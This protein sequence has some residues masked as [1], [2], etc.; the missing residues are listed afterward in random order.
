MAMARERAFD[1]EAF[2]AE[3]LARPKYADVHPDTVRGVARLEAD[4]HRARKAF[5]KSTRARLH[6]LWAA[7]LGELDYDKDMAILEKAFAS[8]DPD[9][10]EATCR[11]LMATHRSTRERLEILSEF[12]AA[13]F[14]IAGFPGVV[15]DLACALHPLGLRAMGLREPFVYHAY[16]I[17]RRVVDFMGRYFA[18]EG[19]AGTAHWRDVLCAPPEETGDVAFLLK[20]YHCLEL[21]ERGAGMRVV[22]ATPARWLAVSF[23]TRTLASKAVDIASNYEGRIVET[24]GERGWRVERLDFATERVFLIDKEAP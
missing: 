2:V 19:I 11:R 16:D 20:M 12:Y 18:L 23:P 24:A 6:R 8:D 21:R 14:S 13:V 17:N 9:D 10:V 7:Y 1:I 22:E 5:E 3:T 4:R 15:L